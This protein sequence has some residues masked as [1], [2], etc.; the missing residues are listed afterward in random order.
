[1]T[2]YAWEF[3]RY[4]DAKDIRYTQGERNKNMFRIP[5][6]GDNINTIPIHVIF[7]EDGD[8]FVQLRCW[9]LQNF[10]S[11]PAVAV[12]L[13]NDLNEEYR[14]IKFYLDKDRDIVA[15][16]DAVFDTDECGSYCMSLV[17]RMVN[18]LDD[19]YPKIAKARWS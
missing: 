19:A 1:M 8:P 12:V 11:N 3:S 5:Y 4:L 2:D 9:D 14:W 7:D 6:S 16:L 18:I 15:A 13:C 10:K 17:M